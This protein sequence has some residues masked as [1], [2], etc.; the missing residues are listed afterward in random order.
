MSIYPPDWETRNFVYSTTSLPS[1]PKILSTSTSAEE[2][3]TPITVIPYP[4]WAQDIK[5]LVIFLAIF[6]ITT[7]LI[8]SKK[9]IKI[10]SGEK[11]F[12]FFHIMKWV[13]IIGYLSA[14]LYAIIY[15]PDA[16]NGE[17]EILFIKRTDN[18][19][20]IQPSGTIITG[21]VTY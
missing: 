18:V 21:K 6:I 12:K 19:C 17:W 13:F 11:V 8:R 20:Y 3:E 14:L 7:C 5:I 1:I 15:N 2:I 16:C 10:I 4:F 9:F